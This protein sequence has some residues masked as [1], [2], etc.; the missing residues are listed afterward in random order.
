MV[1]SFWFHV[2]PHQSRCQINIQPQTDT[3]HQAVFFPIQRHVFHSETKK[4]PI[5]GDKSKPIVIILIIITFMFRYFSKWRKLYG[6][7]LLS[8]KFRANGR[9]R[10]VGHKFAVQK[11]V[12]VD[13]IGKSREKDY[14]NG[15][16]FCCG[17][18]LELNACL[19]LNRIGQV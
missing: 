7:G 9:R 16:Y 14:W 8:E 3:A 6:C 1:G 4:V 2:T 15:N 12:D 10:R 18:S 5:S 11:S 13:H 17:T 19:I